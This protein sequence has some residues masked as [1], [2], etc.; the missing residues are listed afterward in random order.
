MYSKNIFSKICMLAGVSAVAVSAGSAMADKMPVEQ[1]M[2]TWNTKGAV[3]TELLSRSDLWSYKKLQTYN[4]APFL[5]DMVKEG[6]LPPVAERLPNE[7][8]VMSTKAMSDGIGVYGGIFRHVIGGRPEGW[9]WLAGQTQGWGGINMAVQECLVRNGPL[10]QVKAEEQ[11][12]PL[13]NL[14]RSWEWNEDKTELT[15]HLIE[16]AKWSDGNIFDTEDIRFWWEDNVQDA[17][18]ASR[19]PKGGLG[20]GTTLEVLSDYSFKFIFSEPQGLG[21]LKSLAY[22]QGCPGPAHVLKDKHPKYNTEAS[23]EDYRNAQPA[24]AVP[25]VVMGAWVPVRHKADELVIMR[26]NPYYWKTDE[27]GNQ[28]PY[29]NEMHFKLTTWSDRTTQ[30]VAGTGDFSNM[31]NPGNFVEALKQTLSKDAPVK[32]NFGTR[33]LSWRVELNFSE[34]NGV[35]DEVDAELRTFFRNKDFRVA[36]SHAL[37]RQS[38]GQ[39]VARGPFMYPYTGGFSSGSPF[40]DY[41]STVYYPYDLAKTNAMLDELGLKDTD[42]NGVRNLPGT[43]SDLEIDL[44]VERAQ[45]TDKKQVDA[46]ILMLAEAG[47]RVLVRGVDDVTS[48]SKNGDF[49][50][51]I[52]RREWNIPTRETCRQLPIANSCP[53]FHLSGA[54]GTRELMD[55]EVE[56][57]DAYKQI[58]ASWDP[59]TS[60][61]A[62]KKIQNLWTEN[63]YTIGTVQ[64]PAALLVNKRVKNAH[65]GTPVNMF[66]W[67]EDGVV[68]ERLWTP[69]DQQL[70][71]LLPNTIAKY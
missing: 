44:M 50:M 11:S 36:M 41:D 59:V 53:D 70:K 67:A 48:A 10:W 60:A 3:K 27:V 6:L 35:H 43:G 1:S 65:P 55:F 68:R 52:R 33:V 26:R 8:L 12:G 39:S 4:E 37:D 18:V 56:I 19:M 62:A 71:E 40:Y 54:D 16:G 31:E 46:I 58:L 9:N 22:I 57:V 17:N 38:I 13:P 64:S 24:D 49:N 69:K 25:P 30:A 7:P 66:E 42:G 20:E 23:Y 47:I 2:L 29:I 28:L 63:V 15:M 34:T 61:E 45:V 51:L 5:S 32:A 14:A 21:V